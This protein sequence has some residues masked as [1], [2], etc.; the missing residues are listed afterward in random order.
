MMKKMIKD[1]F[2]FLRRK[3]ID[4]DNDIKKIEKISKLK[5]AVFPD[6]KDQIVKALKDK[7]IFADIQE[8]VSLIDGFIDQPIH[9]ELTN[10]FVIGCSTIP[11]IAVVGNRSGRVYFFCIK[12]ITS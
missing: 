12:S 2:D 3:N 5:Y 11:M 1:F 8:T 6:Y 7:M 10:N 4:I 9:N